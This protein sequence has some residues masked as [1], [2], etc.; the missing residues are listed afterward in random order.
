[1]KPVAVEEAGHVEPLDHRD[2]LLE[3][4]RLPVAALEHL[5][6]RLDRMLAVEERDEI[7]QGRGEQRDL[8][9]EAGG[10]TQGDTAL[11]F[12][13]HGEG[14]EGAEPRVTGEGH[15]ASR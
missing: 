9:G 10:V 1:V 3:C 8:V 7:E 15:S 4:R 13:L 14:L 2:D 5:T 11:P 6:D 12:V